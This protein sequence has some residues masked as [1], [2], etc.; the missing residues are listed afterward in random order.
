MI[1]SVC[2]VLN[3]GQDPLNTMDMKIY[4]HVHGSQWEVSK[5]KLVCSNIAL[6]SHDL[7]MI[8]PISHEKLNKRSLWVPIWMYLL[9]FCPNIPFWSRVSL[10][11]SI[12]SNIVAVLNYI[13]PHVGCIYSLIALIWP[14][15]PYSPY[16]HRYSAN[17]TAPMRKCERLYMA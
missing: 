13:Y 11:V 7:F 5:S 16:I 14:Y 17:E 4:V 9:L 6:G 8:C 12:V 3:A 1:E 2:T 15:M 10:M